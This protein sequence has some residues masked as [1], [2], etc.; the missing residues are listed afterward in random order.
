[1]PPNQFVLAFDTSAAHCAVSLFIDGKCFDQRI[2]PMNKG[3]AERL[4]PLCEEVLNLAGISWQNLDAIGVCVGPGNFTG[5]RVGVSA[6]R[7]LSLS[8]KKPAIGISR[9]EAM[10][11]DS[12][13][14]VSVIMDARRENVYLQ[15]FL[16][17][18]AL[19]KPG[20]I[21]IKSIDHSINTIMSEDDKN[22]DLFKNSKSPL[23]IL[24]SAVARLAIDKIG[25]KN[26][27]P[28]PL[29]L[30]EPNADLPKEQP[31][32]IIT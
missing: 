3:Q 24:P 11:L 22:I 32:K 27:R 9:L 12:K 19:T 16:D 2:E 31:P 8:L 1:M 5:V 4:F 25:L 26:S 13:G 30:Q 29:Y 7:G 20:I 10:A 21:N 14:K 6:A 15:D 28:S 23:C 18:T 17:G